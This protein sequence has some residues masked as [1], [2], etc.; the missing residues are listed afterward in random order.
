ME[1]EKTNI[2]Q[3]NLKK[4]F[5]G[6]LIGIAVIA[7]LLVIILAFER[8]KLERLLEDLKIFAGA[9]LLIGIILL[10]QAYKH[11]DGFKAI[12]GIEMWVL[13]AYTLSM[14]HVITILQFDVPTYIWNSIYVVAIYYVIKAIISYTYGKK[15]YLNQFNDIAEIVKE[16]PQK[17]TATKKKSTGTKKKATKTKGDKKK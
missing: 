1:P 12:S 15:Q 2:S 11:E 17:K 16:E 5:K 8:I 14:R 9:F 10:E 13:S 4:V 6:V 7:Y 3:D